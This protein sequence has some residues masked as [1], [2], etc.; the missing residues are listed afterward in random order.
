MQFYLCN[1]QEILK[2]SYTA[3]ISQGYLLFSVFDITGH[4][5]NNMTEE[6][7]LTKIGNFKDTDDKVQI[8]IY[9]VSFNE[10][11]HL[12]YIRMICHDELKCK[13]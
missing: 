13:E 10:S 3:T 7:E 2:N 9:L 4:H 1:V 11:I 6:R 12:K 8:C 5:Y